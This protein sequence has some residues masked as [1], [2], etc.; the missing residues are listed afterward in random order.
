[1]PGTTA[2]DRPGGGPRT[3]EGKRGN[4]SQAAALR[5]RRPADQEP[6]PLR[7]G[8]WGRVT[9]EHDLHASRGP[10]P[11]DDPF[12]DSWTGAS[13][14]RPETRYRG[15]HGWR[16]PGWRRADEPNRLDPAFRRGYRGDHRGGTD[17]RQSR[18]PPNQAQADALQVDE[19][20]R[21]GRDVHLAHLL[22]AG[23]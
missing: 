17:V 20:P 9:Q 14:C 8:A 10:Q 15:G 5:E 3:G 6:A 18:Q 11:R 1:T 4:R 22:V 2:S 19:R 16:D 21:A 23:E 12:P 13:A 7:P